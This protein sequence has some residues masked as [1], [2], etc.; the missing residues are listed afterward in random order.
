MANP[1]ALSVKNPA[2][3]FRM[4]KGRRC[5]AAAFLSTHIIK[6]ETVVAHVRKNVVGV[7]P[8]SNQLVSLR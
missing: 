3:T 7:P 5:P 4:T 6:W 2:K 8:T 1:T